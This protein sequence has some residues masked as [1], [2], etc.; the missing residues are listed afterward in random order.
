MWLFERQVKHVKHIARVSV[1]VTWS[2]GSYVDVLAEAEV[3]FPLPWHK[4]WQASEDRGYLDGSVVDYSTQR[5]IS[6]GIRHVPEKYV[7]SKLQDVKDDQLR[8]LDFALR[9]IG[10]RV[11][12][13]RAAYQNITEFNVHSDTKNE[14]AVTDD[15]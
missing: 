12:D 5:I 14:I 10:F 4:V 13:V 1:T 8:E 7:S 15:E 11:Q 3:K 9:M 6:R 2:K